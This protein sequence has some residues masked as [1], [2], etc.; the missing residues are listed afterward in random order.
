MADPTTVEGDPLFFFFFFAWPSTICFAIP[1]K[2]RPAVPAQELNSG[3]KPLKTGFLS[4][5]FAMTR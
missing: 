4:I 5:L 2:T 1:G 3:S